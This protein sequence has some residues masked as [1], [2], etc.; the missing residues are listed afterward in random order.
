M[1][2][3]PTTYQPALT[4]VVVTF[5]GANWIEQCLSSL[6]D[7]LCPTHVIVVDNGSTDATAQGGGLRPAGG[8]GG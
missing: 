3:I 6:R 7:S 8:G 1:P 5:N 2:S 4:T